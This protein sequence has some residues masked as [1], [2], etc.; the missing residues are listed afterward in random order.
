M[1][2]ENLLGSYL[3][4]YGGDVKSLEKLKEKLVPVDQFDFQKNKNG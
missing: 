2:S 3:N 1:N 4:K